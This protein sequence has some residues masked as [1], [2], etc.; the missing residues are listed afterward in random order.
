MVYWNV[1]WVMYKMTRGI[2]IFALG[3]CMAFMTMFLSLPQNC[4]AGIINA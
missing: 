1:Q 3:M 2:H 4:P